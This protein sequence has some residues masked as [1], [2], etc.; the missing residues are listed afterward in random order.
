[1]YTEKTIHTN[2]IFTSGADH[3]DNT[4]SIYYGEVISIDDPTDGGRIKVKILE[5]DNKIAEKE[6]PYCSPIL[7]KYIHLYPKIGE[8]VRVFIMDVKYPNRNR[9]WLGS[10]ISQPQKIEFDSVYT[11]LSTTEMG[12]IEPLKSIKTNP[13]AKDVFPDSEDI[14][15]I[16]RVN[17]DVILKKN[18]VVIRAGKHVNGDITTLNT[19]NPAALIMTFEPKINSTDYYSSSILMSDKIALLSHDGNPNFKPSRLTAQ[20]RINIF[21]NGHPIG[22]G[23]VILQIFEMFKKALLTHRHGYSNT[24]PLAEPLLTDIEKFE[25]EKLLQK[26]IVT[27]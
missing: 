21:E 7:P 27:N 23:D 24:P 14:G 5:L 18:Q 20:D 13:N 6:L 11:A 26:N 2:R 19:T 3:S 1:M 22:R 8:V 12:M 9:L 16:G 17:T 15:I 4:R 25:L 10:V